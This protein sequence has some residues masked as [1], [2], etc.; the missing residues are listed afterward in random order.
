LP[1]GFLVA[2]ASEKKIRAGLGDTSR[3]R[4][5]NGPFVQIQIVKTTSDVWKNCPGHKW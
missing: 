3:F 4:R 5:I 1:V 2:R